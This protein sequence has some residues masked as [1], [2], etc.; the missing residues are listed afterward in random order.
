MELVRNGIGS[1]ARIE[2]ENHSGWLAII[3]LEGK[4]G[5]MSHLT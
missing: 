3:V 1:Q 4:G 2:L 5:K